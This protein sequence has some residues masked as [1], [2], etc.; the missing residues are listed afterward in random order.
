VPHAPREQLDPDYDEQRVKDAAGTGVQQGGMDPRSPVAVAASPEPGAPPD[1]AWLRRERPPEERRALRLGLAGVVLAF[2][3]LAT[4]HVLTV[5]PFLPADERAHTGYALLVGRGELPTLSTP[6]PPLPGIKSPSGQRSRVYT[7]N[8]PPLYYALVAA[9]LR[10]GEATR[11]PLAGVRAARLLTALLAGAGLVAAAA[12]ALVLVPGRPQLAV[13]AAGIAALLPSFVHLSGLVHNDALGF[14]TATAT[15]AAAVLLLVRGPNRGLL[16]TLA[17]AAAAAALTRAS[18]LVLVGVAV[19]AAGLA[20]LLHSRRPVAAR[21]AVGTLQAGLVGGVAAAASAWFYLRNRA[22]YGDF[23]GTAANFRLFGLRPRGST[24]LDILGTRRFWTG[25]YDQLWGR[26]AGMQFLA[27]GALALP[28]RLLAALV[29]AGLVLG[30]A[31]AVRWR[32]SAEAA[33]R[34]GPV[35]SQLVAWLLTLA[36]V[37][38]LVVALADYVAKGGGTH[39]RYLY[40]GLAVL[41]LVAAVGLGELPGRHRGLPILAVLAGLVVL[42]LLLWATFLSRTT[43]GRPSLAAAVEQGVRATTGLPAWPVVSAAALLLAAAL[44][45][46]A[47]ALPVLA[48]GEG[49]RG[50]D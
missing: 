15:L 24:T 47:F 8:H 38:I 6:T 49:E 45:M 25:V 19:V 28:G 5:R 50:P 33:E 21:L 10:L 9:P 44:A 35:S 34:P 27:K 46:C 31:R 39:A 20:P 23:G 32:G 4:L 41:G 42:N 29:V 16:A 12:L 17:L 13:G 18:G 36:V 26:F 22:L 48:A 2:L 40:P 11:H 7:A 43:P 37:P 3:T 14:T 30:A 1:H